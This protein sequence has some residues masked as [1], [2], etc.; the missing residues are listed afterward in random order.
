MDQATVTV[1]MEQRAA[2]KSHILTPFLRLAFRSSSEGADDRAMQ[3]DLPN[4][5]RM[6][7]RDRYTG[8]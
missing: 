5:S 4:M 7:W 2:S 3:I 8:C 1:F 6:L